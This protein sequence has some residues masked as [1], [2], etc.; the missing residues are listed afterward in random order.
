MAVIVIEVLAGYG[1]GWRHHGRLTW[2]FLWVVGDRHLAQANLH[3]RGRHILRSA[4]E[5]IQLTT[6]VDVS[7]LIFYKRCLNCYTGLDRACS[8]PAEM[9]GLKTITHLSRNLVKIIRFDLR[10][11]LLVITPQIGTYNSFM[12]AVQ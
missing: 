6:S 7:H 10:V 1:Q 8:G 2:T 12:S 4:K 9:N 11:A 3:D 5:T